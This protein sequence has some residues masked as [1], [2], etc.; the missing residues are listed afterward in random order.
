MKRRTWLGLAAVGLLILGAAACGP[1]IPS[2]TYTVEG[3]FSM[4]YPEG[5]SFEESNGAVGF[6]TDPESI[7]EMGFVVAYELDL[8]AATFSVDLEDPAALLNFYYSSSGLGDP[9]IRTD[10][11]GGGEWVIS[12]YYFEDAEFGLRGW[13]A[14]GRSADQSL[15]VVVGASPE[16]FETYLPSYEMMFDSIRF[17]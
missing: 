16:N 10:T 1:K 15:L 13:I 2:E 3:R 6:T 11:F 4:E 14:V 8:L 7:E 17:E 12:D 5:W 9:E